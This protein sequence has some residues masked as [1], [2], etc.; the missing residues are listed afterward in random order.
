MRYYDDHEP[1]DEEAYRNRVRSRLIRRH[2]GLSKQGLLGLVIAGIAAVL[3]AFPN[4]ANR[5]GNIY[6]N[7]NGSHE[8]HVVRPTNVTQK[9]G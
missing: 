4:A 3:L 6:D 7:A 8:L 2:K 1:L 9:H 5:I